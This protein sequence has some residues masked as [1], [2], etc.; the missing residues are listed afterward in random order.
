LPEQNLPHLGKGAKLTAHVDAF[1]D[2]AFEGEIL[3]ANSKVDEATRNIPVRAILK[4]PDHKLLPGM[5]GTVMIDTGAPQKFITLPQTAITFNPYGNTVFLVDHD[6]DN[7][8]VAKQNFVTTGLTRGDQITVLTGVK[9]GDEVVSAGQIKLRNGVPLVINNE[10]QPKND[11][12]PK[13]EDR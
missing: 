1:P 12:N 11:V 13:P 10:I 9:D 3:A 4:N 5:F 8:P 7:K 2:M 6:K